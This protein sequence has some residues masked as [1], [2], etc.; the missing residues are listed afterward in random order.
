MNKGLIYPDE[1]YAIRGAID[2]VHNEMG[3]GFKEELTKERRAQLLNYLRL[4][5]CKMG[6]LVNFASHPKATVEQWAL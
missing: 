3:S 5:K 6:L 2:E 4:T 1:C